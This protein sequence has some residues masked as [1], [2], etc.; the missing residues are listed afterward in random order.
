MDAN[1]KNERKTFFG[2]G[3][4]DWQ[5]S[6]GEGVHLIEKRYDEKK[7]WGGFSNTPIDFDSYN[8]PLWAIGNFKRYEN[9]P[10]FAPDP[11]GWDCGRFGGGVHNG[12]ILYIGNK[13][14]YIY[15]GEFPFKPDKNAPY[16]DL[17]YKCDIGIAVSE[18]GI[19]FERI[20][21][22]S[23]F[24]GKDDD[25]RYSFEDV[26]VVRH[27]GDYYMFLN[28]WDWNNITDPKIS[29][30]YMAHSH[31]LIHW[32]KAGLAFPEAKRIHRN[33]CVL[34]TPDNFAAKAGGKYIMYIND[35][36]MGIS[37]DL[38]HWESIELETS[39]PGG[40]GC[41]ALTDYRK[42][43]SDSILLFTGGHHTGHFYAIGEVLFSKS[44]PQKPIDWL[45]RPVLSASPS[46]PEESC[47]SFDN[48]D[49]VSDWGDT[50]FFT[51]LTK[52]AD[53]WFLYYGGSEYYTCLATSNM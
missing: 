32:E 46:R 51:G 34:Q 27:G 13:F 43:D 21:G 30:V 28:R 40:E 26:N 53:K 37:D 29:G 18:D 1:N 50:V 23:P 22:A 42:N 36:L 2:K 15:R 41:F 45:P 38:I 25:S 9:N 3:F 17:N 19:N 14:Y 35:G 4:F 16:Q 52:V 31:D 7:Y 44:N 24:F 6:S 20:A 8:P 39:W 49:V 47:M 10:V 33:P 48:K 11:K 12:S 5:F